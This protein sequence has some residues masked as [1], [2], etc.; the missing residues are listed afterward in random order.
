MRT[1]V[2]RELLL[3]LGRELTWPAVQLGA[4]TIAPGD[5]KAW[6]GAVMRS[7]PADRVAWLLQL[8]AELLSSTEGAVCRLASAPEDFADVEPLVLGDLEALPIVTAAV[9]LLPPQVRSHVVRETA[10]ACV[11]YSSV[12][13]SASAQLVGVGGTRKTGM[14]ML[15]PEA[16]V[17]SVLHEIA[18]RWTSPIPTEVSQCISVAGELGL[19]RLAE[20]EGW[21]DQFENHFDRAELVADA[22]ALCWLYSTPVGAPA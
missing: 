13:W 19:R 4:F 9:A 3:G 14:I 10:F 6:G 15:G 7:T 5:P 11:G 1:D 20:A 21:D 2:T 22:L 18:H 12:A 8:H 16:D 17:P